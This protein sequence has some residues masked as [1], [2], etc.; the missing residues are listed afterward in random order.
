[1]ST[2]EHSTRW[3]NG[4]DMMNPMNWEPLPKPEVQEFKL[5]NAQTDILRLFCDLLQK[6]A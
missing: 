5:T 3:V 2:P 1:M 6:E 4:V